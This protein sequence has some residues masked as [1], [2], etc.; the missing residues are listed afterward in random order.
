MCT[1]KFSLND[2]A[3]N[4]IRPAFKDEAAIEA[5]LLK[6]LET[7]IMHFE[8]PKSKKTQTKVSDEVTW[9]KRNPVTLTADDIDEKAKYI[10]ER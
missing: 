1:Y 5:W 6:Q 9:F 3:I 2:A 8:L 10:L 4:R 7:A